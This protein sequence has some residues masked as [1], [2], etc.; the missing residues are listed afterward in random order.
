MDIHDRLFICT[1]AQPVALLRCYICCFINQNDLYFVFILL[2]Q[3][4]NLEIWHFLRGKVIF[5]FFYQA[6]LLAIEEQLHVMGGTFIV[7][8]N[9][10]I[11]LCVIGNN[12]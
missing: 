12:K 4:E 8:L 11:R 3:V 6:M 1:L 9:F 5:V 10:H 7:C 2:I